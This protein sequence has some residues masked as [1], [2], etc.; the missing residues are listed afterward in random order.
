MGKANN[1]ANPRWTLAGVQRTVTVGNLAGSSPYAGGRKWVMI[2]QGAR[3]VL[4][5][6]SAPRL[7]VS[8]LF[9][10]LQLSV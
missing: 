8:L 2:G 9:L 5:L 10:P 1:H 6:L 4:Q 7:A 3:K